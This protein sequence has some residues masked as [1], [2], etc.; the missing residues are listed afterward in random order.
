MVTDILMRYGIEIIF[1]RVGDERVSLDKRVQ[2]ANSAKVD[3]FVSFHLNSAKHNR[4]TGTEI[5]VYSKNSEG[6]KLAESIL[7]NLVGEIKLPSRG[8]KYDRLQVV[9]TTKMP[10]AL[11]EV[12]FINNPNEEK[13]LKSDEFLERAAVGIAKGIL[14]HLNIEYM[15]KP[16]EEKPMSWEE[17]QGSEHLDN[18]VKKKVIDSPEFWKEKILEPMPVWAILSLI[19][20]ITDK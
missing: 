5:Y 4:A 1:T 9:A 6:N 3:Y 14:E 15:P 20:R 18:L 19:D 2:I 7:R 11:V 12:A 16:K 8:V 13:P 10:A 17:K